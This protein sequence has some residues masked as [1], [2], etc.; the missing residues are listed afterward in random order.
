[1]GLSIVVLGVV[2]G[3]GARLVWAEGRQYIG[4]PCSATDRGESVRDSA[5]RL[6]GSGLNDSV[7][8]D[9]RLR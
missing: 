2:S 6:S 9:A 5:L 7:E 1:M 8:Y 3:V 4:S